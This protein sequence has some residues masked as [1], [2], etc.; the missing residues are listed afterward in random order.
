MKKSKGIKKN[1]I[2]DLTTVGYI[3]KPKFIM[4]SKGIFDGKVGYVKV[5]RERAIDIDDFYDLKIARFL[6]NTII[7]NN[8]KNNQ[9]ILILGGSGRIGS[10]IVKSLATKGHQIYVMDKKRIKI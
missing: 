7:N 1:N 8:M 2:L 5:P 3:T 4:N 6:L 10:Q 9:N